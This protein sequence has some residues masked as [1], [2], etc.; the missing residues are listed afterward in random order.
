MACSPTPSR[1]ESTSS[2]WS[3]RLDTPLGLDVAL[4]G[5]RL[6]GTGAGFL[7]TEPAQNLGEGAETGLVQLE[8]GAEPTAHYVLQS[9]A[10]CVAILAVMVPVAVLRYRKSV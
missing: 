3:R 8:D 1:W 10:W 6:G 7:S 5:R 9:I 4:L 2:W